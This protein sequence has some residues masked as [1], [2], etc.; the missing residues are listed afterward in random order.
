M[1]EVQYARRP[2]TARFLLEGIGGAL[3]VLE[4]TVALAL[5]VRGSVQGTLATSSLILMC[6]APTLPLLAVSRSSGTCRRRDV[7]GGRFGAWPA[8]GM[9][10]QWRTWRLCN[11]LHPLV[12]RGWR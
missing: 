2:T 7:A 4:G 1:T 9:V 6:L 5:M 11:E 10:S 3:L 8:L 12:S